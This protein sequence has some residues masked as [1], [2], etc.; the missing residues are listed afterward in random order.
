MSTN[1]YIRPQGASETEDETW[2]HL[3]KRSMGWTFAF[4]AYP[5]PEQAP[6]LV[7]EPVTD[8]ASWRDLLS[9]GAIVD[10]Y[11]RELT[12]V[13][14]MENIATLRRIASRGHEAL[15]GEFLDEDGNRFVPVEFC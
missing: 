13:E 9:L 5:D 4:R 2:I 15:T 14:L 6:P 7:K 8:F 1:F 3:G 10:E 11:G 12:P